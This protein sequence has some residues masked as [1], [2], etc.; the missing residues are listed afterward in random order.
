MEEVLDNVVQMRIDVHT[1]YIGR[2]AD[3][4]YR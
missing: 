4:R 1:A 3:P 2:G